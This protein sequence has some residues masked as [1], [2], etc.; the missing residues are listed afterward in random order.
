MLA[1]FN[2]I[3]GAQDHRTPLQKAIDWI[4]KNRIPKSGITVHQKTK[5]VTPEVTGYIITSLYTAGEKELAIDLAKWEASIQRP[6][7]GFNAPGSNVGYTFDTAQIIRGF[8][9]V[10]D[11]LP[12]IEGNLRRACDYVLKFT[13]PD[14]KVLTET[15]DM[16]KL[17]DGSMLSE[18]GNLYV[19]P[20]MLEAGKKLREPRY[21]DA[22]RR[23]MDYFRKKPDL[24]E[25]KSELAMLSHYFG[26]MMEA[27]VDMGEVDLAKKGLAQALKVQREDG[28]I[29]AF[30]GADWVCAT[31]IA[32][33]GIAWAKL[34]DRQPAERCLSY[35]EK[36][37]NPSGGFYG[38]YGN[39]V[40]YF[41]G[42]EICWATKFFIDLSL[43]LGRGR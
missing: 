38:G 5:T 3:F 2:K 40:P 36:I 7:G 20:P 11:D 35:L 13:A 4:K 8:L 16:W 37:Q 1:I 22:A 10:V 33:I 18:Y 26:Y 29:P 27:L 17:S 43:L 23:G 28:M 6:D 39:N 25:F 32:Q 30:P 12:Q 21:S 24:V 19:L 14:G 41:A 34:G 9:S 42:Q 15:Y 31:G